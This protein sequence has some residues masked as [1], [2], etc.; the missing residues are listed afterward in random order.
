MRQP[1]GRDNDGA[2]PVCLNKINP[3]DGETEHRHALINVHPCKKAWLGPI[4]PA[5]T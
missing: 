5:N 3:F 4:E 2:M 1:I